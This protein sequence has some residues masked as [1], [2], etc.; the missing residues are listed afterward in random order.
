MNN[1]DDDGFVNGDPSRFFSRRESTYVKE[2]TREKY[3]S[4]GDNL[5]I[6]FLFRNFYRCHCNEW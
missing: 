3:I 2:K 1:T 5:M 4:I 6:F